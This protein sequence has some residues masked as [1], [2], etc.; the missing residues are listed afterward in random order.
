VTYDPRASLD[1]LEP[2]RSGAMIGVELS[3]E[4][5]AAIREATRPGAAAGILVIVSRPEDR[6]AWSID[7]DGSNMDV[8][9]VVGTHQLLVAVR[10]RDVESV[11]IDADACPS[12]GLPA[13]AALRNCGARLVQ[14][15]VV[16]SRPTRTHVVSCI[17]AGA[18]GYLARPFTAERLLEQLRG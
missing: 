15:I 17:A 4:E 9:Y 1:D 12:G 6:E 3:S 5:L 18:T 11:I 16:A 2:P 13:L 8:A 10:D 14:R 7:L